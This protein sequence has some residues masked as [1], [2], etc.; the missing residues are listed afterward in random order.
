MYFAKEEGRNNFIFHS[1]ELRTQSIE[2]LMLETGLRRALERDEL[3]LHYQP[4]QRSHSAA[5]FHERRGA[6][7][8]A[9]SRSRLVACPIVSFRWPRKPA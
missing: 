3:V 2:R 8:L 6:V 7:A 5:A 1:R 9:P 4:K